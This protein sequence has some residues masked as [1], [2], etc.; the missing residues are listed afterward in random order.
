NLA[1]TFT[2]NRSGTGSTAVV[3]ILTA[4]IDIGGANEHQLHWALF[5]AAGTTKYGP[6][7]AVQYSGAG[8]FAA[9]NTQVAQIKVTGLTASTAYTMCWAA[10]SQ[11]TGMTL[12]AA[13]PG[14]TYGGAAPGVFAGP[15]T[16]TVIGA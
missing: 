12:R 1:V 6:T 10:A 4:Y 9:D 14:G 13:D 15:A 7:H 5:N 11:L 16:M 3:V 2:T 8:N